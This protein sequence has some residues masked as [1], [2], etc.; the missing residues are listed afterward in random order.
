MN[1]TSAQGVD[2][3][4]VGASFAGVACA[5]AAA[6]A[7]LRVVVLERKTDP[8]SKLHTTGIIVREAAEHTALGEAPAHLFRRIERVRLHSPRLR[9]LDLTA[10]GYYFLTTDTPNLLRWLAA[11]LRAA[12]VD[13]RLGQSFQTAAADG[14]G[15]QIEGVGHARW[16]VGADGARSQVA[17]RCGFAAPHAMLFGIE[18]EY[19]GWQLP[20]PEALHCF[21]T[22][23]Y[24]PGY[25]G[26]VAQTPTG[27]QAGL[28]L[29]QRHGRRAPDIA[30]FL[31][32]IGDHIGLPAGRTPD[33]VRAGL[34]P[35]GGPLR[36][37]AKPGVILTGDAAGIVSP[38]TAGGIHAAWAHG[39][40]VALA[41]AAHA[42]GRG[43]A[44]E[45]VASAAVPRFRL[46]RLLRLGFDHAQMDWP[47]D[48]L[49]HS[50]PMRRAAELVYFHRRR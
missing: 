27:V 7:G 29:R 12:G 28:A 45:R 10:P 44:P 18:H 2:V 49:L 32:H 25:I 33:A 50:A 11:Q 22:R 3:C 36:R 35:C 47:F 43:A 23:R 31:A 17:A 4:V 21:I 20:D 5:L 19:D 15:W 24:A 40:A 48:W 1:T 34:I 38:V 39:E 42:R 6:R 14:D 26:W 16:L 30:A 46:K 9:A 41:I 13:L 8:G 37:I